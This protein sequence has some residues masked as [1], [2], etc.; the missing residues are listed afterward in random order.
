MEGDINQKLDELIDSV[1]NLSERQNA[2][3]TDVMLTL[4]KIEDKLQSSEVQ[5]RSDDELY[6]DAK[7]LVVEAQVA[8]TSYLQRSLGIGY[9]RAAHMMDLLEAQGIIG[10]TSGS[11]PRKVLVQE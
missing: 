9:S 8:S 2:Q 5:V 1:K 6:E 4:K 10:P 11:K 7:E 3:Y